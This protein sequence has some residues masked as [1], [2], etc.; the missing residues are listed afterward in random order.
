MMIFLK[1]VTSMKY[2]YFVTFVQ[3]SI[4]EQL[5][6][7]LQSFGGIFTK[8]SRQI[9]GMVIENVVFTWEVLSLSLWEINCFEFF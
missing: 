1:F 3:S 5:P 9:F 6:N 2:K 7:Y 8:S 4:E